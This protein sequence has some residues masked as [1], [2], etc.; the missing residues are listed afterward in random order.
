MLVSAHDDEFSGSWSCAICDESLA[1]AGA[2]CFRSAQRSRTPFQRDRDR[3]VHSGAFRKMRN[4]TQ[5]FIE[6][7]AIITAPA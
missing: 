3:I 4:K 1:V 6:S 5:V 7:E 2:F